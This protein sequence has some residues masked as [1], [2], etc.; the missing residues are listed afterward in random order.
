MS[1]YACTDN[2]ALEHRARALVIARTVYKAVVALWIVA[3]GG[4]L[5]I[6]WLTTPG[7]YFWPVWPIL[8]MSA[9]AVIWGLA[10]Y[11]KPPFRVSQ[12]QVEREMDRL[13]AARR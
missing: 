4:M 13:R 8:G 5:L 3:S 6:W 2:Y 11:G 9:A 1:N 12:D 10:I 7:G